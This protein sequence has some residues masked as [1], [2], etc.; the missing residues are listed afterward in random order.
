MYNTSSNNYFLVDSQISMFLPYPRVKLIFLRSTKWSINKKVCV[1]LSLSL[2]I[3][4]YISQKDR[5]Q[6][7]EIYKAINTI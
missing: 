5:Y 1:C 6:N 7:S 3:Y 2:Y 4:I